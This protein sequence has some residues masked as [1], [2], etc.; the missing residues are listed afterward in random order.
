MTVTHGIANGRTWCG[1]SLAGQSFSTDPTCKQCRSLC[2]SGLV[3]PPEPVVSDERR[4]EYRAWLDS[5]GEGP[6]SLLGVA[7]DGPDRE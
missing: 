5:I 7:S 1:R 4:A 2:R 6:V 3:E